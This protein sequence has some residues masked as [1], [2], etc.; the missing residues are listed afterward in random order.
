MEGGQL[1]EGVPGMGCANTWPLEGMTDT[2]WILEHQV[3]GEMG[4][5]NPTGPVYERP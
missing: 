3:C 4:S 1:Q 5:G 2:R